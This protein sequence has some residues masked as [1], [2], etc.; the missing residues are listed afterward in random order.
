NN[1]EIDL[2]PIQPGSLAALIKLV[3]AQEITMTIAKE[4]VFPD[5]LKTGK[6]A[7]SIIE[8]KGLKPIAE[9][10][11]LLA[12]INRVLEE[13]PQPVSQYLGGKTQVIGFLLG[14]VMKGSQGKASPEKARSLLTEALNRLAEK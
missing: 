13:N 7:S 4:Q 9:D 11:A 3:E 8:E 12:I 6:E 2:F 5:L 14:Q 10:G 1:L